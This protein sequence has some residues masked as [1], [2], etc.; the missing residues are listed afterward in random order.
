MV[1]VQTERAARKAKTIDQN[2]GLKSS[3]DISKDAGKKAG[4]ARVTSSAKTGRDRA[5]LAVIM[6][7]VAGSGHQ[8]QGAAT[9]VSPGPINPQS[10]CE[11]EFQQY[12]DMCKG[13]SPAELPPSNVPS[14]YKENQFKLPNLAVVYRQIAGKAN[15]AGCLENDFGAAG[16]QMD[17]KRTRLDTRFMDAQLFSHVNLGLVSNIPKKDIQVHTRTHTH[18][19]THTNTHSYIYT[20]K[21]VLKISLSYDCVRARTHTGI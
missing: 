6:S 3:V 12:L 20:H 18:T 16:T 9:L 21:N 11:K 7:A 1:I 5:T 2:L 19:H 8:Q 15:S 10:V 4:P 13:I 17:G 14:W